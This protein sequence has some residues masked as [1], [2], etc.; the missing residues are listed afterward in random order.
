MGREMNGETVKGTWANNGWGPDHH[1]V[2]RVSARNLGAKT[3]FRCTLRK[4]LPQSQ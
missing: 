4:I 2:I 3:D 1:S